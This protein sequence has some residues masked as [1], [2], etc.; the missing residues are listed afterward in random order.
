MVAEHAW[1]PFVTKLQLCDK[2]AAAHRIMIRTRTFPALASTAHFPSSPRYSIQRPGLFLA[3]RG[4]LYLNC[5][6]PPQD[7]SYYPWPWCDFLFNSIFFLN[8]N[9]FG[10]CR[11]SWHLLRQCGRV[12]VGNTFDCRRRVDFPGTGVDLV[13]LGSKSLVLSGE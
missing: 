8:K 13:F 10:R 11:E 1:V 3:I 9:K 4:S 2:H 12:R 7:L 5:N 6:R